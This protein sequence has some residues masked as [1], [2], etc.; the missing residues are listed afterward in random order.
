LKSIK[1]SDNYFYLN[2]KDGKARA[3]VIRTAHGDVPTPVFMP[4]GTQGTVKALE[5]REL[6]EID[7]RIILSN[8]YHL[9]LR[10]GH[11]I[12]RSGGG[13]HEFASWDRAIL[14]DSGGFQVFSLSDLRSIDDEGVVFRSHIDGSSHRFTPGN[15][16]EIQ[17]AIGSDIMM[18]LDECITSTAKYDEVARAVKRTIDW[19]E[20]SI[21]AYS[22]QGPLFGYEQMLFGIVQGGIHEALREQCAGKLTEMPFHGYA[23]GGLAVGEPPEEMYRLAGFTADL[24]PETK[25]RY[26]MGVGTPENLL[27]AIELGIDMFDCVMPTRNA[28]NGMLFTATG[29]VNIRNAVHKTDTDPVDPACSCYAC[30]TFSRGYLRHLFMSKEIL[31]LQLATIHNITY[32]INLMRDARQAIADGRYQVWMKDTISGWNKQETEN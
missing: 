25:V 4:V 27:R 1:S 20:R 15:V 23:I 22:V 10:P 14:T 5:Q 19:A 7:A 11:D 16:V 31:G 9:Y 21:E 28:R 32:Y 3:G 26:L 18:Q 2:A 24:L 29:T 6:V 12:V 13:L 30:S 8:T 17:R